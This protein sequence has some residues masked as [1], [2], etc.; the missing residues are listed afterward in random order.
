MTIAKDFASKAS[1][2]FVA[3]AMIFSMV[4]PAAQAQSNEDLQ[5]M[6]N[7]L[8]AQIAALQ[9]QV[10]QGGTSVA[11]GVCP[12]TW[13]RDLNVGA[14]GADV[15][16]LQ[17]FLNANADTRVAAA[18]AGSVGMETEYYG[19]ATAAAVSK[20]QV[21]Y[22]ADILTPAALV[23]PTG[24]FGPSSRAK[25]NSLCTAAPVVT[26][27][28]TETETETGS[29]TGSMSLSGEG[30]LD[31]VTID[32]A[33]DDEIEEGASDAE[34]AEVTFEAVDGDIEISRMDVAFV[35]SGVDMWDVLDTVSLWVDGDMVA[36][37][38][39]SDEDDFQNDEKSIRFS[40]LDL[41]VEEDEEL[42]VVVAVTLQNNLDSDDLSVNSGD[43][44]V[45][46]DSVR[47]FDA[48]GVA[49]TDPSTGELGDTVTFTVVEAGSDDEIIVK[50]ST[51]D[52][53]G[54]T[55][56][57]EDDK[58][59]DWYTT[60]VFDLDTD[61]SM[62]DIDLNE[63]VVQV[64]LGS[65]T[66]AGGYNTLV[67]DAEIVIDGVT[68]DSVKVTNGTT[69]LATLTFDVDGDVTIDA[70]DRVDAKLMLRFKSLALVNEGQTLR[71][72]I[73]GDDTTIDAE[74]ADDLTGGQVSGG[75]T[76]EY[77]TLRTTGINVELS[78]V[79]AVVTTGD[80]AGDDYATYTIEL[81]VTAFDQ[82]VYIDT[83]EANSLVVSVVN[84]SGLV[85]AGNST[86]VLDSTADEVSGYFEI[87][88]GNT[89]TVTIKV[90][91]DA[92][93]AGAAARLQL[94]SIEFDDNT[95][96]GGEKTWVAT[97]TTDYRT[98]IV[99][100]VN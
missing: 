100:L 99:T 83:D 94:T 17:Q 36:E 34:V 49:E 29:G 7:T 1:I 6:I 23:N 22:R 31:D 73:T 89:E 28:E 92:T 21:M 86:V 32:S 58:K 43:F 62:N 26:P 74:G 84:S 55:L 48:D 20:M 77:H 18:G 51:A 27:G 42:D 72:K 5:T 69:S 50:T 87:T 8:L 95:T 93:T 67:D 59:S 97:P 65:T 98:G 41:F 11:S 12:F 76:G 9:G 54:T 14:T 15:M 13:T 96:A 44:S 46:V 24:Y 40:G 19:P 35:N 90:T 78:E 16:K 60:F 2:A 70:G 33:S 56:K 45:S 91:F 81:D 37:M 39:A 61:D 85:V 3:L 88:E 82:D 80:N 71:A 53:D 47:Y 52:P 57:V 10:G 66:L 30:T 4:A 79:A 75:A 25:A 63:I 68:I 38:D 64:E